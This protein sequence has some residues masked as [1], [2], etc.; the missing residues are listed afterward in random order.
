M[1]FSGVRNSWLTVASTRDFARLAAS[2]R[3]RASTR[4]RYC[5]LSWRSQAASESASSFRAR[6]RLTAD[7]RPISPRSLCSTPRAPLHSAPAARSTA[8]GASGTAKRG[9]I[10]AAAR[11]AMAARPATVATSA[12]ARPPAPRGASP[13]AA[14]S[15]L[16]RGA[17]SA[18]CEAAGSGS[19][20]RKI[21][22]VPRRGARAG[23]SRD[24]VRPCFRNA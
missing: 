6:P 19:M 17:G 10:Q 18:S 13:E 4:P 3:S 9:A 2:A 16:A 11:T 5:S 12:P 15:A 14:A 20:E 8:S 7:S 21:R 1:P 24:N 22:D 23:C